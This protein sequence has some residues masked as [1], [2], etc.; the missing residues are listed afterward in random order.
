MGANGQLKP[1][2]EPDEAAKAGSGSSVAPFPF[3][4]FGRDDVDTSGKPAAFPAPDLSIFPAYAQRDAS[5]LANPRAALVRLLAEEHRQSELV[6]GDHPVEIGRRAFDAALAAVYGPAGVS[7]PSAAGTTPNPETAATGLRLAARKEIPELTPFL[8]PAVSPQSSTAPEDTPLLPIPGMAVPRVPVAPPK[9]SPA[10]PP[11]ASVAVGAGEAAAPFARLS[12]PTPESAN[13]AP[14]VIPSAFGRSAA[15]FPLP[16]LPA[17]ASAGTPRTVS[18]SPRPSWARI[19]L[20]AAALL[21]V[22]VGA[23]YVLRTGLILPRGLGPHASSEVA[24]PVDGGKFGG[25]MPVSP[26]VA[27]AAPAPAEP[28]VPTVAGERPPP[29]PE[30][31]RLVEGFKISGVLQGTP[32]VA[33]VNGRK[34]RAGELV[35]IETNVRLVDADFAGRR[36][37][38]E[39]G[40]TARASVRY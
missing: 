4:V 28:S 1:F 25:P 17:P 2:H 37:I 13:L 29:S 21:A 35:S 38:F 27:E 30:F 15:P 19:A 36:L 26:P 7:A 39:D 11:R 9:P 14:L 6:N 24:A 18:A 31:S 10:A 8:A 5:S 22:V 40:T 32:V 20:A 16:S 33:L 3:A 23:D 34:I 12:P